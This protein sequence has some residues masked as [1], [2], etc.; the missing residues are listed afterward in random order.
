MIKEG[1]VDGKSYEKIA[2]KYNVSTRTVF[3]RVNRYMEENQ[4]RNPID[5]V[6]NQKNNE[7]KLNRDKNEGE[8]R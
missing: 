1:I 8:N 6:E 2:E 4:D 3:R 5:N 7:E